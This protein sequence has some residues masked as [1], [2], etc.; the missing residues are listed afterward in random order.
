MVDLYDRCN[1]CGAAE[2]VGAG[3]VGAGAVGC[4]KDD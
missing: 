3:V 4:G 1:R 2:V